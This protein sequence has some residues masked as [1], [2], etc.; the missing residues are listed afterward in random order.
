[1]LIKRSEHQAR[2]GSLAAAF[3]GQSRGMDRRAFLRRSG[4]AVG[5]LAAVGALPLASVRK[6]ESAGS[7]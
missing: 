2:R 1:M 7:M 5:G 3:A 6:A 4:L